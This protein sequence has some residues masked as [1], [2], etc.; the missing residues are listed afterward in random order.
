MTRTK[1]VS[2]QVS[3]VEESMLQAIGDAW[4]KDHGSMMELTGKTSRS[5]AGE[6]KAAIYYARDYLQERGKLY[7]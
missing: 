1:R 7:D 5:K 4:E 6:L 2:A 3:E